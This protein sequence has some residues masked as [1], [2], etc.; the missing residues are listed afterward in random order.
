MSDYS[1][2]T[3]RAQGGKFFAVAKDL[4]RERHAADVDAWADTRHAA[5]KE[6]ERRM[7]DLGHTLVNYRE[8]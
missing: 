1:I 6:V 3:T 8:L 7:T 2:T 4:H 5:R